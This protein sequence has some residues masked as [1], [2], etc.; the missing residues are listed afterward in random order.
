[1]TAGP[2]TSTR[3]RTGVIAAVAA[4]TAL[5]TAT[6]AGPASAEPVPIFAVVTGD[7]SISG[8]AASLPEGTAFEGTIDEEAGEINGDITYPAS[9]VTLEP[10][11]GQ[12]AT[13]RLQIEQLTEV[14]GSWDTDTGEAEASTSVSLSIV[15]VVLGGNPIPVGD[16]CTFTPIQL[17]LTGEVTGEPGDLTAELGQSGFTIPPTAGACGAL[18]N[19]L[20]AGDDNDVTINLAF[21]DEAPPLPDP[22]PDPPVDETDPPADDTPP[23]VDGTPGAPGA[24]P[25]AGSPTFTG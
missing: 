16:D 20:L 19:D 7:I 1:M 23:A 5:A 6:I 4:A 13:A 10:I 11:P 3:R 8:N 24:A 14:V 9:D 12:V 2:S 22:L 18:V 15:S 17:D 21:Q 25:I